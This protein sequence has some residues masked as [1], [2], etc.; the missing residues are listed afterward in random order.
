MTPEIIARGI[1][2]AINRLA[3]I[4]GITFG[5]LYLALRAQAKP[6]FRDSV[7]RIFSARAWHSLA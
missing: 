6:L 4:V 7:A 2:L 1:L 5:I 3:I